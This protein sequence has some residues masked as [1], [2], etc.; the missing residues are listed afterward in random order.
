MSLYVIHSLSSHIG[1]V[2]AMGDKSIMLGL[3]LALAVAVSPA[4]AWPLI[5]RAVGRFLPP[6]GGREK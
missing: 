5:G 4:S 1:T 3:A 6:R 2:L